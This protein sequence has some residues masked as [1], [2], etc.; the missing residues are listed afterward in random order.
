MADHFVSLN[1]GENG[2]LYSDFAT[3]TTSTSR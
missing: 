3:A 1:R 2:F